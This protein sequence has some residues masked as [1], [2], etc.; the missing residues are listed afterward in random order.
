MSG[1]NFWVLAGLCGLLCFSEGLSYAQWYSR[2][3]KKIRTGS[4]DL[5]HAIRYPSRRPAPAL[6]HAIERQTALMTSAPTAA[7]V[8]AQVRSAVFPLRDRSFLSQI[9]GISGSAFAL[10]EEYQGQRYV[11]GVSAAH[12]GFVK[13]AVKKA[14]WKYTPV[15]VLARGN[16]EANDILLFAIPEHIAKNVTPLRLADKP[17]TVGEELYSV[18]LFDKAFQYEPNR[19]VQ[20]VSPLRIVTSLTVDPEIRRE[21]ACGGPVLNQEGEVVGIHIGSSL[22][23]QQGYVAS[24]QNIRQ[25]LR[26]LHHNGEAKT[27]L[28]FQGKELYQ[29]NIDE[30]ILRIEFYKEDKLVRSVFTYHIEKEI[31]YAHLEKHLAGE[32]AD[33]M[34]LTISKEP[35]LMN[36]VH[37]S[38]TLWI[39]YIIATGEVSYATEE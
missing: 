25:A 24:L 7:T 18:G 35:M 15:T 36:S 37:K 19:I 30:A 39:D 6:E 38:T 17:A 11:W 5:Y 4:R 26:A 31:D 14:F 21:G 29:L 27:R 22:H 34:V 28:L 32:D 12:Y 9:A 3:A 33:L 13:P 8:P 1:K 23:K 2:A 10:E 20:E 16:S